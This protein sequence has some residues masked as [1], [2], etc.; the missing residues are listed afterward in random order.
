MVIQTKKL[1]SVTIV[2]INRKAK[3]SKSL[4]V[5]GSVDEVYKIIQKT[6]KRAAR[7]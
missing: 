7:E 5:Y 4:T 6:L 2:I 1:D 3:K